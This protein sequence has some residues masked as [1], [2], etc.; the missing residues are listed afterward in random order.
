[1]MHD[2]ISDVLASPTIPRAR[3]GAEINRQLDLM[4]DAT[5][6]LMGV[7]HWWMMGEMMGGVGKMGGIAGL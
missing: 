4:Q 3:K 2:I 6:D 1:M 5:R 7:E